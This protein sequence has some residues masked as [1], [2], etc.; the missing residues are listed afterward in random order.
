MVVPEAEGGAQWSDWATPAIV[1]SD[2][3]CL[4]PQLAHLPVKQLPG[5]SCPQTHLSPELAVAAA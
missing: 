3:V 5:Q 2:S 1:Q 4:L